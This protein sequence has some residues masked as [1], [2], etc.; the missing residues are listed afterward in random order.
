MRR[1]DRSVIRLGRSWPAAAAV[2]LLAL[3]LALATGSDRAG[4][5]SE[6]A[7]PAVEV[8]FFAADATQTGVISLHFFVAAG[9]PVVFFERV[10][11]KLIPLG[12]RTSATDETIMRDAVTWNCDRLVRSFAAV[13]ALPGGRFAIG[14]YSVRTSSCATRLELVVPR[15]LTPGALGRVS[16]VDRWGNG[17]V[18]SQLCITPPAGKRACDDIRMRRAVSA[19]TRRFRPRATGRWRVELRYRGHRLRRSV[20]VGKD[21]AATAPPPVVLATGDSTMQG[22]DTFLADELGDGAK[23]VSDVHPST[24]I[25]KPFGPWATLPRM[26][27]RRERQAA[28]VI[29]L[30][31]LD[32]FSLTTSAG[33]THE[34]CGAGWIAEYTRR[35]RAMMT[36]YRRGGN[37][38]VL[39]L[40]L[41]IPKGPRAVADAVN[42]AVVQAAKAVPGVEVLRMDQFFTPN[43]FR[44]TMPYRGQIVD[45][46]EADGIHLNITG[47]VIAAR[48][49]AGALRK[50]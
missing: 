3:V 22:I 12:S 45:V 44:E 20:A 47:Q 32:R 30:G 21:V 36:I 37:T 46:R 14:E 28:T 23:V 35:V 39:W 43:G 26:Q 1:Y 29:S 8:H 40:T 49:V 5:Q 11:G 42:L 9:T 34:C 17:D 50:R 41:P 38:R 13:A 10:D 16:V 18:K 15:R 24:A 4:A 31:I 7:P 19:A 48:I 25:S 2:I 27:T 33:V 6:H